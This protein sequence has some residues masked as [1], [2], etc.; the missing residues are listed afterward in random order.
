[1]N[2]KK[3]IFMP[4][5]FDRDIL[6]L[7]MI[8]EGFGEITDAPASMF[9]PDEKGKGRVHVPSAMAFVGYKKAMAGK[10]DAEDFA[11]GE[12]DSPDGK[13]YISSVVY[14]DTDTEESVREVSIWNPKPKD[15]ES[16]F[17]VVLI[18]EDGHYRNADYSETAH[19]CLGISMFAAMMPKILE[20][21]EE[22][23]AVMASFSDGMSEMD[24]CLVALI[25]DN[26]YHRCNGHGNHPK[27]GEDFNLNATIIS[28]RLDTITRSTLE[29][30]DITPI[31]GKFNFKTETVDAQVN[32]ETTVESLRKLYGD[33]DS[34][35]T[36]R[37]KALIP[38]LESVNDKEISKEAIEAVK[39]FRNGRKMG[40]NYNNF[41][42]MGD[43]GSGKS[44]DAL[45][46]AAILN[47]PFL[48][49]SISS[50][51]DESNIKAGILPV[52]SMRDENGDLEDAF[53]SGKRHWHWASITSLEEIH[54]DPESAY[55]KL[56]GE[57][58]DGVTSEEVMEWI[59]RNGADKEE[60]KYV[61]VLSPL[62]EA[63]IKGYVVEIQEVNLCN[64]PAV[65]PVINELLARGTIR[66]D[67]GQTFLRNPEGIAIFT[68]N[69]DYA[70]CNQMNASVMSRIHWKVIKNTPSAKDMVSRLKTEL[71]GTSFAVDSDA[72]TLMNKMARTV[73]EIAQY[74]KEKGFDDGACGYR[75]LRNWFCAT[76]L[77]EADPFT[78]AISTVISTATLDLQAQDELK[79]AVLESSFA[80]PN[81]QATSGKR[82]RK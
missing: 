69:I 68:M 14:T 10:I 79:T 8:A 3:T 5:G 17:K 82:R 13:R 80:D 35:W 49:L 34:K 55:E 63:L 74:C 56:T 43:A 61:Y 33:P 40:F 65:L 67:N 45:M 9:N 23:A 6:P 12:F 20:E 47:K 31:V 32:T 15:S 70:G 81:S 44:T 59:L 22:A 60:N 46:I 30:L 21:T 78:T 29:G 58:I 4:W 18:D 28:G 42:F 2:M 75:E 51:T 50:N 71:G 76:M 77:L 66:M 41:G 37:E 57:R 48:V 54:M 7:N 11:I 62:V 73:V 1:M 39:L 52:F 16:A 25:C 24:K 38:S 72:E 36:E 26:I 64:D 53:N 27:T 19:N